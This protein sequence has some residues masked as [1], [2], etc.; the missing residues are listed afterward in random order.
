MGHLAFLPLSNLVKSCC[1]NFLHLCLFSF[2]KSSLT[3]SYNFP[4]VQPCLAS[5]IL[6]S[7]TLGPFS[8]KGC[9]FNI[10]N[11]VRN[12]SIL[13]VAPFANF[14]IRFRYGAWM[15]F[16]L[17]TAGLLTNSPL[18]IHNVLQIFLTLLHPTPPYLD[19]NYIF[20]H[21]FSFFKTRKIIKIK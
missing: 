18:D 2:S 11:I 6:F 12:L 4:G 14:F 10:K 20:N 9:P 3:F 7:I 5:T 19:I 1:S 13:S 16:S 17:T 21:F 15:K 8:R